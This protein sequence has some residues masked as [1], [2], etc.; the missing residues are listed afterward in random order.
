MQLI[1]CVREV[2]QR[3]MRRSEQS[4]LL[5]LPISSILAAWRCTHV[6][7]FEIESSPEGL[8]H[9]FLL[10]FQM[11]VSSSFFPYLLKQ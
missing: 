3:H 11:I 5:I 1:Q 7:G 6:K 2:Y 4:K 10:R 8:D 9:F